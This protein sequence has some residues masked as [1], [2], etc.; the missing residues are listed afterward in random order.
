MAENPKNKVIK[1]FI[2]FLKWINIF[3]RIPTKVLKFIVS[4][5]PGFA[6]VILAFYREPIIN[7]SRHAA[8]YLQRMP[9]TKGYTIDG[10][11][12]LYWV[13]LICWIIC[14]FTFVTNE[15]EGNKKNISENQQ[16]LDQINVAIHYAPDPKTFSFSLLKV[17]NIFTR[18]Q[19]LNLNK[20]N[21]PD[22]HEALFEKA[23]VGILEL[24]SEITKGFAKKTK[25]KYTANLMYYIEG[26]K[27]N[28]PYIQKL[29][30]NTAK[31][32]YSKRTEV[33]SV[34]FVLHGIKEINEAVIPDFPDIALAVCKEEL[35]GELNIKI[36]GAPDA[37]Y[38]EFVV[39]NS[40]EELYSASGKF[41][42]DVKNAFKLHFEKSTVNSFIS[43]RIPDPDDPSLPCLGVIN[44][45]CTE[46]Y[47]LGRE[48]SYYE[49]YYSLL[50]PIIFLISRHFKDYLK[51]HPEK[52]VIVN[53]K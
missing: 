3:S 31:W 25:A 51:N 44:I 7:S 13:L 9:G 27:N 41:K 20:K 47:P 29:K 49:T 53:S 16:M 24:I 42:D 10:W 37:V 21:M 38:N 12:L 52:K 50:N 15:S 19:E 34:V 17:G 36:P 6:A 28:L 23:F 30:S 39:T 40:F 1:A 33:E 2:S 14:Y 43:I 11:V 48:G 22:K 46:T 8:H 35:D 5:Y 32:A 26:N 4:V 18:L 45:D